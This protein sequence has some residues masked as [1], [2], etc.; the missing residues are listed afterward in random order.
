MQSYTRVDLPR[1][2]VGR[3][4]QNLEALR[5][6]LRQGADEILKAVDASEAGDPDACLH[7]VAGR[8]LRAHLDR[9]LAEKL[10]APD[11]RAPSADRTSVQHFPA[12]NPVLK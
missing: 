8:Q 6:Q 9:M 2:E 1:E 10:A 7:T 11:Q 4:Q 3:Q 5:W 12:S